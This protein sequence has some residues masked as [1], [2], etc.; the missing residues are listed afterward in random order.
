M[1][2]SHFVTNLE[3]SADLASG[4]DTHSSRHPSILSDEELEA[5]ILRLRRESNGSHSHVGSPVSRVSSEID[6]A[7]LRLSIVISMH[8]P[9][10]SKQGL[11]RHYNIRCHH[12]AALPPATSRCHMLL[13]W[14]ICNLRC[15]DIQIFSAGHH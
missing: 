6:N 11:H 3:I 12:T 8:R 1:A 7:I 13:A 9:L 15:W 2:V 4:D 5:E 14:N 10:V